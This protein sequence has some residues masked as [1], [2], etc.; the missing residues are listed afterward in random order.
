M[1]NS[2]PMLM[3]FAFAASPAIAQEAPPQTAPAAAPA[4]Q[5][6]MVTKV[7]CQRV[8]VEATSG[9]RLSSSPRIC[10]KVT[11]PADGSEAKNDTSGA[12]SPQGR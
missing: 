3:I 9:S 8:D 4:P 1:R 5:V 11:V 10:K 7:V 6:K 12:K 2:L